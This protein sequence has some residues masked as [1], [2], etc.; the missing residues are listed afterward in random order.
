[1]E[2]G[3]LTGHYVPWLGNANEW[4]SQA[5]AYGW[6]VSSTP[7]V[8]SIVAFDPYVDGAGGYGHVGVVTSINGNNFTYGSWNV[9]GYPAATT[10]Y[11]TDPWPAS[12]VWFLTY[13]G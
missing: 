6:R 11:Q 12:G 3:Q 8:P 4:A 13:P 7:T 1:M 2:Y 9:Y 10:V 5:R